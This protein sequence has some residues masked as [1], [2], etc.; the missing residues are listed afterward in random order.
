VASNSGIGA[1]KTDA[2]TTGPATS[3]SNFKMSDGWYVAIACTFGI[4]TADT[5][6]GPVVS[7]ILTI[8]LI[9]QLTLLIQGK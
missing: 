4:I 9:Y 3:S 7:G 5:K 8:G 1:L 6:I 2:S